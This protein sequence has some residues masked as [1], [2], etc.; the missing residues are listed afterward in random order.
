M[1]DAFFQSLG[2]GNSHIYGIFTPKIGEMIQFDEHIFQMGWNHQL[3]LCQVGPRKYE[4]LAFLWWPKVGH[5]LDESE[6]SCM[7]L[8]DLS[9]GSSF[10]FQICSFSL[11]WSSFWH[12]WW[13]P[14][15]SWLRFESGNV[16]CSAV[17]VGVLQDPS[18]RIWVFAKNRGYPQIIQFHRVFIINHPFWGTPIFGNTHFM[19]YFKIF[20]VEQLQV[21]GLAKCAHL[22]FANWEAV[23]PRW[24]GSKSD[25]RWEKK[26]GT[27]IAEG[28]SGLPDEKLEA[29]MFWMS[30][31]NLPFA[32]VASGIK[33]T[34]HTESSI[35]AWHALEWPE[36]TRCWTGVSSLMKACWGKKPW[37]RFHASP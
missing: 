11:S 19:K 9:Q 18:T 3:D 33:R 1:G 28:Q 32:C 26:R 6:F 37:L 36:C 25:S 13:V 12:A 31:P 30:C 22:A 24:T 21:H 20:W 17:E 2:G 34:I 29:F 8:A 23:A 4:G 35:F 27:R 16:R 7:N 15:I 14:Y 5:A 10:R